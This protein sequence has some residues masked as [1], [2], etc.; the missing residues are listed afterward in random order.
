MSGETFNFPTPAIPADI[1]TTAAA[2]LSRRDGGMT[3]EDETEFALW[4]DADQRHAQAFA[5]ASVAWDALDRVQSLQPA[6]GDVDP[7]LLLRPSNAAGR[8]RRLRR[9]WLVTPALAAAMIALGIFLRPAPVHEASPVSTERVVSTELGSV[10]AITLPDG[11]VVH[12]NTDTQIETA[13][14]TTE[15]RVQ[16][17]RG[18][19]HF[20]VAP[21]AQRPFVVTAG[22]VAVQAVGTEFNVWLNAET[23][24]VLVTEGKVNI[25]SPRPASTATSEAAAAPAVSLVAGERAI[26][27]T[28]DN[29]AAPP[30]PVVTPVASEEAERALAWREQRLEFAAT[31]LTEVVAQFNRYNQHKLVI[32]PAATELGSVR[33]GGNFRPEA[34]ET[35]VRLLEANFSVKAER[36]PTETILRAAK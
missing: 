4:L 24:E 11:S 22:G 32:D 10:R 29:T 23:I 26:I 16:V 20:K 3:D 17:T 27:P 1:R 6:T 18:E 30:G 7:D 34:H 8:K 14:T 13:F 5:E 25:T 28:A 12:L 2:W 36:R 21:N 15:R 33:F 31:P 9:A 35:L 19:A